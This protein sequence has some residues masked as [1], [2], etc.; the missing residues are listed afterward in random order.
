MVTALSSFRIP[1]DTTISGG[2]GIFSSLDLAGLASLKEGDF[3]FVD[4]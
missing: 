1:S 3:V 4:F 2:I